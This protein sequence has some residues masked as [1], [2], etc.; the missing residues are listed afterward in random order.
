MI[1]YKLNNEFIVFL[2]DNDPYINMEK[3][4]AYY[5]KLENIKFVEFKWKWHFNRSAWILELKE[6]LDYLK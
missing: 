2:S 4:K 5:S 3:A 6:I 1:F